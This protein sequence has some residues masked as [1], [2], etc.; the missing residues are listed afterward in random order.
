MESNELYLHCAECLK[1]LADGET[2]SEVASQQAV[3]NGSHVTILC[4][5]HEIEIVK[6]ELSEKEIALW[7]SR[8]CG[9]C[10]SECKH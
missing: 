4:N 8:S 10:S 1:E 2:P 3:V 9:G 6:L 7:K 5:I